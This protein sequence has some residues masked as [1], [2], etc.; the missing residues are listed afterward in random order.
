MD[1]KRPFVVYISR[2]RVPRSLAMIITALQLI[3]MVVGCVVNVWAYQMKQ[4]GME[5]H[6]SD[7]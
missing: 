5:C 7:K 3:Q 2:F 6:V 4:D 1:N